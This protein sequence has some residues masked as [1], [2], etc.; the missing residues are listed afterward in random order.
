MSL[1]LNEYKAKLIN[2][3]LFASSQVEVQ[4]FSDAAIKALEQNKVNEYIISRFADKMISELD[5]FSPMNKN[6]QQWSNIT[7]ARIIFNRYKYKEY[8]EPNKLK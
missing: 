4:R 6:A 3:I 2:K 5:L 7:M 8:R 1:S